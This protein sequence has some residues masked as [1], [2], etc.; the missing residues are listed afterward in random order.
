ML[1]NA[2]QFTVKLKNSLQGRKR[3][4]I[5]SVGSKQLIKTSNMKSTTAIILVVAAISSIWLGVMVNETSAGFLGIN[6]GRV[7]WTCTVSCA[8]WNACF[9]RNGFNRAGCPPYPS[10]CDCSQFAR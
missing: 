10:R 5:C 4:K 8:A 9:F 1:K 3:N 7:S 6:W 2:R